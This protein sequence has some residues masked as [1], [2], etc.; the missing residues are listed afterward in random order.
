MPST[1]YVDFDGI[2][3][4]SRHHPLEVTQH[5]GG[6]LT[7][8]DFVEQVPAIFFFHRRVTTENVVFL[9][10]TW[11][12]ASH[13]VRDHDVSKRISWTPGIVSAIENSF[14]ED[15]IHHG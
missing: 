3:I 8:A 2:N 7:R 6:D 15:E 5:V 1:V 9:F 13:P 4:Q 11:L 12:L 10:I 14:G